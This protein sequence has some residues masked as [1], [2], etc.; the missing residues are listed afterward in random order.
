MFVLHYLQMICKKEGLTLPDELAST[1]SQ[2]SE[3]NLRRAILML[4][5]S[6]VKQLVHL[7]L[8]KLFTF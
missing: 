3:R 8:E 2:N 6:K 5:A 1:I 4:E 7:S